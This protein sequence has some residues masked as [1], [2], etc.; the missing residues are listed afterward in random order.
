MHC[1]KDYCAGR[2][3]CG[4]PADGNPA[5]LLFVSSGLGGMSG[6]Q[7]KAA[8][9]AGAV[10]I[11]AEVDSSRVLTRHE[12]GWVNVVSDD[13]ERVYRRAKSAVKAKENTSI[14]FHGNIVDLLDFLIKKNLTV[15]LLSDQTSC[16][17]VYDGGYCPVGLTFEARTELLARDRTRFKRLVDDSL[18]RHYELIQKLT[19]NGTYFFD[20]GNAFLKRE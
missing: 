18:K 12:Q 3:M 10:S 2:Q 4:V 5:G 16:H 20:Y 13:L 19:A 1:Q 17:V 14:A 9:I 8:K 7:P 11:I 6:A 15:D